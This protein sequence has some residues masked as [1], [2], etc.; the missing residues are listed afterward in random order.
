MIRK[1]TVSGLF[2]ENNSDNLKKSIENCF[3]HE[4]GPGKLPSLN[5]STL[6]SNGELDNFHGNIV[7]AVVPHAGYMYS[8]PIAA[9]SYYQLVEN[10]FPD[11]FIILCPN[12]TGIA[13]GS[14]S[15][16]NKGAWNTPLGN[17]NIDETFANHLIADLDI[18][19]SDFSAHLNEHSCEVH[20]PF[21]QYFSSDFKIL[22][23]VTSIQSIDL[24]EKLSEGIARV[25]KDLKTR[26]SVI[27]STDLTHYKP[28]TIAYKQDALIIDG[29]SSMDENQLMD[30]I[31]KYDISMC[32]YGPTIATMSISKKLGASKFI[33]LNYATSGDMINNSQ[34][35]DPEVV[36]YLS[37]IFV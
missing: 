7:G 11:T 33:S 15:V 32:G 3:R 8:G 4:L 2:Y 21:L 36:G 13:N 26:I 24:M 14:I 27:A 30:V 9:N 22:P 16:F 19:E 1:P 5:K 20:L 34:D 17:V 31:E 25:A 10:G 6:E 35:N 37:G 18:V 28:K 23:I 29:I 12:H